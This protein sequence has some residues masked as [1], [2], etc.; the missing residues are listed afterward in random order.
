M[1]GTLAWFWLWRN[2]RYL[3]C[4][5]PWRCMSKFFLLDM[6]ALYVEIKSA[7]SFWQGVARASPSLVGKDGLW[8]S[9]RWS[10]TVTAVGTDL[11]SSATK[12]RDQH[13]RR[14]IR[15]LCVMVSMPSLFLRYCLTG[16]ISPFVAP[17]IADLHDSG[18]NCPQDQLLSEELL[19]LPGFGCGRAV[20]QSSSPG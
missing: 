10:K 15:C 19:W 7:K 14:T 13:F 12:C 20:C 8:L 18:G 1:W 17:F 4:C 2:K 5:L 16:A 9:E 3:P 6:L 11:L